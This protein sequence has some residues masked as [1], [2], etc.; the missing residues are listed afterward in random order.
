MTM[1]RLILSLLLSA[2]AS[3]TIYAE[4]PFINILDDTTAIYDVT[5]PNFEWSQTIEKDIKVILENDGLV[6]ESKKEAQ[7]IFSVVDLPVNP[8]E[9]SF[10]YGIIMTGPKLDDK[11]NVGIIFD[12]TDNHNFKGISINNKQYCYF[13]SKNGEYST[14]K[15]GLIKVKGNVFNMQMTKQGDK[16]LFSLN[17]IEFAKLN[18][19]KIENSIFGVFIKGKT[20][21][22]VSSLLFRIDEKD[23]S[24]QSTTDM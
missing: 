12:Y 15:T 1:K 2:T 18:K 16:V 11:K 24:E 13:A 4:K 14:I 17:G 3:A 10:N 5:N 8:E 21:A 6:L 22:K 19:V 9:D 23:D 20:K 7:M